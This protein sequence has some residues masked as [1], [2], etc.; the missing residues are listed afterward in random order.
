EFGRD[1]QLPAGVG[2]YT[3]LQLRQKARI[4]DRAGF[5]GVERRT[6][7]EDEIV[8]AKPAS[9]RHKNFLELIKKGKDQEAAKALANWIEDLPQNSSPQYLNLLWA[10]V[11]SLENGCRECE[12]KDKI[13]VFRGINPGRSDMDVVSDARPFFPAKVLMSTDRKSFI[14]D[15]LRLFRTKEVFAGASSHA[16]TYLKKTPFLSTSASAW[17]ASISPMVLVLKVCPQRIF[18]SSGDHAAEFEALIPFFI[19]PNEVYAIIKP[20]TREGVSKGNF[21]VIAKTDSR[22][23][24]VFVKA[25]IKKYAQDNRRITRYED[26]YNFDSHFERILQGRLRVESSKAK[27]RPRTLFMMVSQ[28]FEDRPNF[29]ALPEDPREWTQSQWNKFFKSRGE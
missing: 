9:S 18:A 28:G 3:D 14:P 27:D 23:S 11:K 13:V 29:T 15:G 8:G 1:G 17:T 16:N 12:E 7:M 2:N 24:E 21:D 25:A 10:T 22:Q 26:A 19:H 6:L 20:H 5:N 4:L